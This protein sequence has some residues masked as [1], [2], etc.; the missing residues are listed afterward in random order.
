MTNIETE[1]VND[2][3]TENLELSNNEEEEFLKRSVS[4]Y[5][6]ICSTRTLE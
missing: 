5:S 1:Y 3:E 2:G 6:E 4:P